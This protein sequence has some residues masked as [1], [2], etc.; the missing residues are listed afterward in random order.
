MEQDSF[1][2]AKGV[3][4][5]QDSFKKAYDML[6][7][8]YNQEHESKQLDSKTKENL[9]SA[10]E[11]ALENTTL[12]DHN[13]KSP[14]FISANDLVP[15]NLNDL[16]PTYLNVS[17]SYIIQL[18]P[19][20]DNLLKDR[21]CLDDFMDGKYPNAKKK[22]MRVDPR[23]TE[24]RPAISIILNYSKE[25]NVPF[26]ETERVYQEVD[27]FLD[28][29][30]S[31]NPREADFLRSKREDMAFEMAWASFEPTI[32]NLPIMQVFKDTFLRDLE[33]CDGFNIRNQD[34]G[35]M[36]SERIVL[37]KEYPFAKEVLEPLL[38]K[39]PS[40]K[41]MPRL[42]MRL[43]Y[44]LNSSLT[45]NLENLNLFFEIDLEQS[46]IKVN[47]QPIFKIA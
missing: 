18:D 1:K 34:A 6:I 9:R 46:T 8:A 42:N 4:M 44:T 21:P 2:K 10:F 37:T 5:E 24:N 41:N 25:I 39:Y 11:S 29:I 45:P 47:A 33:T 28:S 27:S 7:H 19:Q 22:T 35:F 38:E 17:F 15:T 12:T 30:I 26:T 40:F 20:W 23:S 32:P 16:V 13:K 36:R 31:D 14:I 3:T 43:E